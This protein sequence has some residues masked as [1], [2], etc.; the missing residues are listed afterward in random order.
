[1]L[2]TSI[3]MHFRQ[4]FRLAT[5]IDNELMIP[6][7]LSVQSSPLTK[8][9]QPNVS[10]IE[11]HREGNKYE[12]VVPREQLSGPSLRHTMPKNFMVFALRIGPS[13]SAFVPI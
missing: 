13:Q 7:P 5:Q 3:I 8:E 1:M 4:Y 10:R 11:S 2:D 12:A 6:H 9:Y